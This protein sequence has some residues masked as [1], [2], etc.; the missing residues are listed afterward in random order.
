[1][2]DTHERRPRGLRS[3]NNAGLCPEARNALLAADDGGHEVGYGDDAHTARAVAAFRELFGDGCDVFFVATGTAANTLA[4]ASLVEPWHQVLCHPESHYAHH[5]S[6]APERITGCR[7]RPIGDPTRDRLRVDDLAGLAA[8]EPGDVHEA[9]PGVLTLT[10]ATEFGTLYTPEELRALTDRAHALGYRVHV[11]GARFANA[12]AALGCDPRALSVDCGVDALSFGGTKNGLAFGEAV[13]FFA[14]GDGRTRERAAARFP[15]LR[16]STGHLLSKHRFASAPFEATLRGGSPTAWSRSASTSPFPRRPTACSCVF[17]ARWIGRCRPP[18]TG[19]I[20]SAFRARESRASSAA[21]TRARTTSTRCW[22]TQDAHWRERRDERTHR[23]HRRRHRRR[24][25]HRPRA[26]RALPRRG[27]AGGRRRRRAAAARRDRRRAAGAL[28]RRARRARA[29]RR[30]E[31]RIGRRPGRRGLGR[32]RA[33]RRAVQQRRRAVG[34]LQLGHAARGLGLG[35]RREP[36]RCHPRPAQL[37]A[38]PA[39]AGRRGAH[40]ERRLDGGTHDDAHGRR[41]RRQQ[42]RGRGAER[43]AVQ[44]T[45]DAAVARARLG[46]VPRDDQHGDRRGRTQPPRRT[47]RP[48]E[49]PDE[50][51]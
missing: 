42:A 40:R 32:L 15:Y 1:M 37:R 51:T 39:R 25:R 33:R 16:K 2:S 26:G 24:E 14:Q 31:A 47:A 13:L 45:R 3:D 49:Q 23:A 12:V 20:R 17:R 29:V 6:T 27:D 41:L 7:T 43:N 48:T 18:G 8:F 44:G 46:A 9:Q 38:A 36:L 28:V 4:I 19:T 5:E 10:N 34:R 30:G 35:A 21:S 11:D 22:P 50:G